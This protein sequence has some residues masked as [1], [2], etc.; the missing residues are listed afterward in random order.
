[1]G[2]N[3]VNIKNKNVRARWI[4]SI[5]L[6]LAFGLLGGGAALALAKLKILPIEPIWALPI[7]V[8]CA[9]L[10][11]GATWLLLWRTD[12]AIAKKLDRKF[13][14]SERVQTMLEYEKAEGAMFE[15][16]RSDTEANLA[17]IPKKKLRIKRIWI[18]AVAFIL[19]AA[20][21]AGSIVIKPKADT[22][23]GGTPPVVFGLED[24]Q[25]AELGRLIIF[26]ENSNM[27]SPYRE[28]VAS[29]IRD[30]LEELETVELKAKME[31]VVDGAID[32]IMQEMDNASWV[33]E[34]TEILWASGNDN[35]KAL[36]KALN[37]YEWEDGWEEGK[38]K[39]F[40]SNAMLNFTYTFKSS[41]DSKTVKAEESSEERELVSKTV[42]ALTAASENLTLSLQTYEEIRGEKDDLFKAV[43]KINTNENYG[44]NT[45]GKELADL[46]EDTS[47]QDA[48]DYYDN[49]PA[50]FNLLIQGVLGDVYN[51]LD[52]QQE[53]IFVGEYAVKEIYRIFSLGRP[54]FERPSL[55]DIETEGG[56]SG[57]D[58]EPL[59]IPPETEVVYGSKEWILD[60][61][62]NEQVLYGDIFGN[63]ESDALDKAQ[64]ENN[65]YTEEERKA[66]ERYFQI[67]KEGFKTEG[68]TNE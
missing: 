31:K 50:K 9:L 51:A 32:E 24:W 60:P 40:L 42:A 44:L 26:V 62:T 11:W 6:G 21:L 49:L 41:G 15:L 63:Y 67:L 36:A 20:T 48:L 7:G 16:Q 23:G 13:A 5:L 14:L 59:P 8:G 55:V 46:D 57:G 4:K 29:S 58:D 34:F 17:A 33:I 45:L 37:S 1:M 65:S 52:P 61:T 28:N 64:D 22:T 10:V 18:Y 66:I 19:G 35:V 47:L 56:E 43:E 39:T 38:T 3:F 25:R 68:E 54:R 27:Q 30:M 2:N 12:K 53:N